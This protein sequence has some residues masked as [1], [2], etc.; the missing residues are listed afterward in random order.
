MIKQTSVRPLQSLRRSAGLTLL[1]LMITLGELAVLAALALPAFDSFIA[2]NRIDSYRGSLAS[3][4]KMARAQAVNS[5]A[6]VV[7]CASADQS[8]CGGTWVD[9][10][11]TFA[12]TDGSGT[13]AAGTEPV[14]DVSYGDDNVRVNAQINTVTFMA[15]GIRAGGGTEVLSVC[16]PD[17]SSTLAGKAVNISP[18]GSISLTNAANC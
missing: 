15:T 5:Q 10:W 9:G 18:T 3:S 4:L 12:D 2:T 16:H 14:S 6:T 13:R 8:S 1:D 17:T 7:M 11:I